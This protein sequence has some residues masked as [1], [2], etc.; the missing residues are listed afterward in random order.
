MMCC[1]HFMHIIVLQIGHF[2]KWVR[3][4][5]PFSKILDQFV[6][7]LILFIKLITSSLYYLDA[8]ILTMVCTFY[9][10]QFLKLQFN[11]GIIDVAIVYVSWGDHDEILPP[12][13]NNIVIIRKW[14]R[15]H[16]VPLFISAPLLHIESE[17]KILKR[18]I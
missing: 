7:L 1:L 15:R 11:K 6:K 5:K 8:V 3:N 10:Y 18:L 13:Y 16:I 2:D 9:F 17:I 12:I 4:S 14:R